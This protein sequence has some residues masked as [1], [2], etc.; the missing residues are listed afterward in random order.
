MATTD[1]PRSRPPQKL[2]DA[3]GPIIG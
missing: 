3:F 1:L 2:T